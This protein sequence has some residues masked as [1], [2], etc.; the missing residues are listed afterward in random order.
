MIR[1]AVSDALAALRRA[2]RAIGQRSGRR[3]VLVDARTPVNFTMVAPLF[4]AMAVDSRIDFF[5]TASEE[6]S[7]L[8]DI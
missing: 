4:R 1:T 5:F 2:D 6:P 3:S 7:R 8:R